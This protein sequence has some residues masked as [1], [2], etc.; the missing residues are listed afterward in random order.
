MHVVNLSGGGGGCPPSSRPWLRRLR[1]IA[2]AVAGVEEGSADAAGGRGPID[3]ISDPL[4]QRS[5]ITGQPMRSNPFLHG[6]LPAWSGDMGS[7][8][9]AARSDLA[10]AYRLCVDDGLNEGVCNHL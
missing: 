7:F 3:P 5:G 8:E 6:T 1:P 4:S 10:A 2:A 9:R